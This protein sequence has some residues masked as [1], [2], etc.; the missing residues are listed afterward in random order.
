MWWEETVK[1]LLTP[2]VDHLGNLPIC[3]GP[4]VNDLFFSGLKLILNHSK[5]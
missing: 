3:P 1:R 4:Q 2:K 5:S